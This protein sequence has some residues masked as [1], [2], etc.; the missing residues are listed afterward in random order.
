MNNKKNII[1]S[2]ILAALVGTITVLG[3]T[4]LIYATFF[5]NWL[6]AYVELT[7]DIVAIISRENVNMFTMIMA[8]IAHGFLIA[9]VLYWGKFFTSKQGAV[10]A[11]TIAFLTELYFCFSQYS[12]LKTMSLV[13]TI[14]DT[15]MWTFINLFV[16]IAISWVYRKT[17]KSVSQ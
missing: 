12:I 9:I 2:V 16:G 5:Q 10:A 11:G 1:K 3:L 13:T 17:L 6:S 4:I 7:P 8:N 14:A 15:C